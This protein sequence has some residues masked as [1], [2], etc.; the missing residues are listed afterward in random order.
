MQIQTADVLQ[1]WFGGSSQRTRAVG[2]GLAIGLGGGGLGLL[3]ALLGPVVAAGALLGLLAGLYIL[4]DVRAAL[5]GFVAVLLLLPFGT[6]PV[7]IVF[8]PTLLDIALAVFVLVYLLLWMT[9]KRRTLYLTPVHGLILAY[10]LW[11]V[12]SFALG[13]QYAPPR[14]DILRQFAET[15]L[16]ISLTFILVDLLREP[17]VLRR[18]MLVIFLLVGLQTVITLV[19]YF[20]PDDVSERLLVTLARIGYPNGG[21]I[22]YVEDN[23]EL[24]ERAIGTWVDPNVLGGVL[25]IFAAMLAPQVFARKPIFRFRL[26][27]YALLLVVVVALVLTFSRAA[28]LGFAAGVLFIAFVRY[29]RF[30]PLMALGAALLLLLPQTQEYVARF[31]DA[32]AIFSDGTYATDLAT[33]M[34]VG[35]YRDSLR[36]ISRYPVF[37]VGFTGVPDIDIY[38]QVAS[39][40]LIMANHIGLVG[41]GFF[42]IAMGGVFAYGYRAWKV[43]RYQPE[44]DAVLLGNYAGLL[45]VLTTSILDMYF[46]RLDFQ[47]PVTLFWLTV[48]LALISARLALVQQQAVLPGYQTP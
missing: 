34:R 25:A 7:K 40:Y 3:I 11:F 26:L 32:F 23:S 24:A 48:S 31:A 38:T 8:T 21:V 42:L 4:T 17:A 39:M 28:M 12:L 45:A 2:V 19:L 14:P 43:A 18:L 22:R 41:L 35:E 36:L 27:T 30:I 6:L 47:S 5:Y 16:A 9:G 1:D 10:A 13:L 15:L 20:L 33:Q 46:F 37:G 44:L 29:R